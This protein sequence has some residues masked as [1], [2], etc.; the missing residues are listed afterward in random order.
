MILSTIS[1]A[2]EKNVVVDNYYKDNVN[3]IKAYH[4]FCSQHIHREYLDDIYAFPHTN[5]PS[6]YKYFFVSHQTLEYKHELG[7]NMMDAS[8]ETFLVRQ[9]PKNLKKLI[10]QF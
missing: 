5:L 1:T 6:F 10:Q 8:T 4:Q 9:Y 2:K 7:D 3:L